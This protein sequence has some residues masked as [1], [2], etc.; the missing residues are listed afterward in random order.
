MAQARAGGAEIKGISDG[1][2]SHLIAGG[3][4]MMEPG[5]DFLCQAC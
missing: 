2:I 4:Q 5:D 1:A 3:E